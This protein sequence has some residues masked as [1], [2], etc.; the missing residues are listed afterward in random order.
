MDCGG[1]GSTDDLTLKQRCA[2]AGD[3]DLDRLWTGR[4]GV[5]HRDLEFTVLVIGDLSIVVG[6]LPVGW[7]IAF[8]GIRSLGGNWFASGDDIAAP[9]ALR[10]V[11]P[12]HVLDRFGLFIAAFGTE[13]QVT[14]MVGE[15]ENVL[16]ESALSAVFLSD[17]DDVGQGSMIDVR[18]EDDFRG[19]GSNEES[20]L[21]DK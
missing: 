2:K 3:F 11:K 6:R 19:A 8:V 12:F 21:H 16:F 15:F 1:G 9:L 13:G 10:L 4:V 7:L 5:F 20:G 18:S 17:G 14:A